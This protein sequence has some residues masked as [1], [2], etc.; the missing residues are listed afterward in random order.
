MTTE[1]I[2]RKE[3]KRPEK[4]GN[5]TRTNGNTSMVIMLYSV[6][7]GEAMRSL[8]EARDGKRN[9][10]VK[11]RLKNERDRMSIDC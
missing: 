7:L 4:K 3:K 8:E 11:C 10:Q 9:S 6:A 5:R 1:A 2:C